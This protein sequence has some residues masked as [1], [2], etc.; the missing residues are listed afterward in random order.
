MK[1]RS[2]SLLCLFVGFATLFSSSAALAD[3]IFLRPDSVDIRRLPP[4][5]RD[6]S[7]ADYTDMNGVRYYQNRRSRAEC[8]RGSEEA[9]VSAANFFGPRRG[10]LTQAELA[11]VTELFLDISNDSEAFIKPMK[12]TYRRLRPFQRDPN[13]RLCIPSVGGFAYPSGH[14]TLGRVAA[15]VFSLV[16]PK[17]EN[18]L[19]ARGDEIGLDRVIGGV[20]HPLD[21]RTGRLLA[22]EIYDALI[23]S[24]KFMRRIDEIRA[25]QWRNSSTR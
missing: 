14:A 24:P 10:V 9:R 5:P 2:Q 8:A 6:G 23:K 16:F 25:Q 12:K 20:H 7:A 3:L 17:L 18:A 19:M 13:I 1:L 4:P 11:S 21:V 15:R 22:D